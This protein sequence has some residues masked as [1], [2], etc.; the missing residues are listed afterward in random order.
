MKNTFCHILFIHYV[1]SVTKR[2]IH[3]FSRNNIAKFADYISSV[4]WRAL[5]SCCPVIHDATLSFQYS[6]F[7]VFNFLFKS[8]KTLIIRNHESEHNF[9]LLS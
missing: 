9:F 1:F 3:K 6:L 4:D 2:K 7:E 5:V 8:S